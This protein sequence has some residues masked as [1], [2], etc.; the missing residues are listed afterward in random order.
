MD[1]HEFSAGTVE[2]RGNVM[3]IRYKKDDVIT[4]EDQKEIT[5]IRKQI[6][7]DNQ[8]VTLIDMREDKIDFTKEAKAYVTENKNIRRLR[9]A[10]VLLVKSFIQKMGIH[11]YIKIFR[12]KDN[13][14]VMT[15]EENALHWLNA[16]YEKAKA[17]SSVE[18]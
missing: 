11:S 14:T 1:V 18:A 12:S 13:I 6:F 4:L 10:E 16:Q 3:I 8:Y 7:G 17:N 5:K 2:R 15:D 9:I